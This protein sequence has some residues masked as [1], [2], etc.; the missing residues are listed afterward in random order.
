MAGQLEAS[1]TLIAEFA[2]NC[3]DRHNALQN[4]ITALNAKSDD[5]TATWKGQARAAFDSLMDNYFAQARKLNDT[6][7][8]TADKLTKA[9]QAFAA[10]DEQFAQQVTQQASSLNLP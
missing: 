10:Q 2:K 8:Q 6:L 5:T 9:G 7:D 3:R 4:S 1:E